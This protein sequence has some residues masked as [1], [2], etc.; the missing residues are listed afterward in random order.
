MDAKCWQENFPTVPMLG[1]YAGGEIGPRAVAGN[2]SN[3]FQSG[4]AALQGFTAVFALFIVPKLELSGL[5]IDDG[6]PSVDEFIRE[7][8]ERGRGTDR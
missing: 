2:A 8:I 5:M 1:F 7:Y 3:I 4:Q 6:P